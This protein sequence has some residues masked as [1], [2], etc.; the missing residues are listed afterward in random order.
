MTNTGKVLLPVYLVMALASLGVQIARAE[1][2]CAKDARRALVLSGGGAKGAFEAGAAYHLIVLRHCD[3]HEFSG[4]SVGALNGAFLAQAGKSND[5]NESLAHLSAEAE[6]LV[7]LWQSIKSSKGIRKERHFAML[8]W[9]LFGLENMNDMTPLRQLLNRNISMGKLANGRPVRTSVVSFWSGEY[10]EVVAHPQPGNVGGGSFLEYL[11][12][13]STIPVYA[14]LPKIADGSEF[15]DPKM[16]PQFSDS[17]VRHITPLSSYFKICQTRRATVNQTS[18]VKDSCIQDASAS[19][20]PHEAV[21]QLFVIVTSP[22][23]RDSDELPITDVKCCKPGTRQ[24]T[25]GRKILARTL[26]LMDDSVYRSDLN[27]SL[28]ANDI[29]R[30]RWQA[31]LR[32]VLTAPVEQVDDAKRQ[33]TVH[34]NFAIESYNRGEQDIE[35]PSRPYEIGLIAPKKE[36][37]DAA[38]LLVLSPPIIQQQLYCGC[39]AADDMMATDFG[40]PSLAN[41][42]AQ[43]FQRLT[44]V[45]SKAQAI[46]PDWDANTC[47]PGSNARLELA[48]GS[49]SA[50]NQLSREVAPA[51]TGNTDSASGQ[52]FSSREQQ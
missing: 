16:W 15:D 35:A 42:C 34:E 4:S 22:F 38:H 18:G 21:E 1:D 33:F 14:K 28:I 32:V 11:Y 37:A 45:R 2:P 25:D 52:S 10:R 48:T 20:P 7:S 49:P 24:I 51:V 12:A 27:F 9:G 50:P 29:V 40:L 43:R 30:W 26:A 41:Q 6:G 44:K 36:L 17:G 23:S 47:N 39:V 31:Y 19:V 13:S 46:S 8:R 3:F 5:T